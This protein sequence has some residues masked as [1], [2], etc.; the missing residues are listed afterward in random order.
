MPSPDDR[1]TLALTYAGPLFDLSGYA[2]MARAIV[3][4]LDDLGVHVTAEPLWGAGAAQIRPIATIPADVELRPLA[5]STDGVRAA[6]RAAPAGEAQTIFLRLGDGRLFEYR[7]PVDAAS[8]ERLLGC[9]A[10]VSR[11]DAPFVMHMIPAKGAVDFYQIARRT[12]PGHPYYVG[13]TMFETAGL[14]AGWATAANAMDEIWVPSTFNARTFA[15]NGVFADKLHV[16]PLGVDARR[17]DPRRVA[18]LAIDEGKGFTF[19]S[20][21]QWTRRKGWDVLLRAYLDAF[22]AGDDVRLVLR[23]YAGAGASAAP[24]LR[25]AIASLGHDPERC[26]DIVL[27]DASIPDALLP[28]LYAACDAYVLPSRGEGWGMPYLEAMAMGKATIA[29]RASGNL[30]FMHDENAFL[31]DVDGLQPVDDEQ[32][33]D[34]PLYAGQ[35]WA[36]PSVAHT[37]ELLRRVYEDAGERRRRG[38]RARADVEAC[39]TVQRQA[40][41]VRDRLAA[42]QP[43]CDARRYATQPSASS[44]P[45]RAAPLPAAPPAAETRAATAPAG[46][47]AAPRRASVPG[48]VHVVI[49]DEGWILEQCGRELERRLPYVRVGVT[50][51]ASA[52]INYYVNYSAWRGRASA[53]EIALFTHVEERVPAAAA[54]FF[55]VARAM[56][57]CICMSRLYADRLRDVDVPDVYE[58]TPGVD[59]DAYRPV[60]RIAV[61]GRTYPSGRKGE[62]LVRAVM[63]EPGIE[64]H[65]TGA[66][67]PGPAEHHPPERMPQLYNTVDYVLVPSLYEGGPMPLLEALACGKEVIAPP[68]G[69]VADYPHI[70]YRTGDVADLRR[71][72]RELVARRM[73]LRA[74]VEHRSWDAWASAHDAIFRRILCERDKPEGARPVSLASPAPAA[75]P[76]AFA[77]PPP[78]GATSD[79]DDR[80]T[81]IP[82]RA[83]RPASLRVL[84]ALHAPESETGGGPSVR[85]PRLQAQLRALGIDADVT[86]SALPDPRGYTVA[87]VFNV[88]EP[89]AAL[90][91]LRHFRACGVP[92]VFSPIYLDLSELAWA[93]RAIPTVFDQASSDEELARYLASIADGSLTIDG[94]RRADRHELVPGFFAAVREMVGLADHVIALSDVEIGRLAAAGARDVSFTLVRNTVDVARFAA[95]TPA[96]F[97]GRYDIRDYVLCVGRV[98]PRKNQLMLAHALRDSGVPLV[99]LGAVADGAYG[100]LVRRHGGAAVHVIESLP[101]DSDLLA[102]AYAGARVFALPSWCEGA[103]LSALEAAAAGTELVLSDRSAEAEYFGPAASYCDPGDVRALRDAVLAAYRRPRDEARRAER[104][105][106]VAAYTWDDVVCAT[107]DAYRHAIQHARARLRGSTQALPTD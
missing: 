61:V 70:A 40:A 77:A 49:A 53:I 21:F 48:R 54:R 60:V 94:L 90:A 100:A 105:A 38:E 63:D 17:F 73:V 65:F 59:L 57:T 34:D 67:W 71:V 66:G 9:A 95:A 85:V 13:S 50:A 80:P 103:P 107:L 56:T 19:L 2:T 62:A 24:R 4:G 92:V 18:P 15:A 84:L 55:E 86:T 52:A 68:V 89:E 41:R 31:I 98:E 6:F 87:H 32:L 58:I 83:A 78:A 35:L 81:D 37:T 10:T 22:R 51:D 75:S 14:P 16:L 8:I 47:V 23:T 82:S 104:R 28:R 79:E 12:N 99:L 39:W 102:S 33:H 64:W 44:A 20:V 11:R 25:E 1:P 72:L 5:G 36:E 91:Q 46:N 69:F 88:W 3:L 93:Q 7:S 45:P 101:H 106:C 97:A 42:I 27:L 76:P 30:D 74:S 29:T 26:A 96:A 43:L